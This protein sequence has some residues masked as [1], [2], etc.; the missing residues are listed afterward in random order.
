MEILRQLLQTANDIP[1][2]VYQ[3]GTDAL[4]GAISVSSLGLGIQRQV[5]KAWDNPKTREKIMVAFVMVGSLISAGI[6]YLLT[7]PEF[8]PWIILVT[9]AVTFATTQPVYYFFLKPLAT[10]TAAW[11]TGQVAKASAI[12][13]AKAAAVPAEGLPIGGAPKTLD[14]FTH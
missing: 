8:A 6:A 5:K 3:M 4:I 10:R 14:D 7:V 12:N 1:K 2:E 13:E 9:G 11:M